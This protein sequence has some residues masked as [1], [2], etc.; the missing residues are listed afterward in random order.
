MKPITLSFLKEMQ[1]GEFSRRMIYGK[2]RCNMR[3]TKKYLSR[4]GPPYP[5]NECCGMKRIGNDGR[6]YV[7][8]PNAKGVCSWKKT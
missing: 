2:R 8:M 3:T 6:K 1:K 7:S 4:P 5:A